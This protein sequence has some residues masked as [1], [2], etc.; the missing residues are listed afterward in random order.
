M[1]THT[2]QDVQLYVFEDTVV[3]SKNV[4]TIMLLVKPRMVKNII[5]YFTSCSE[6]NVC[7]VFVYAQ[8]S[9]TRNFDSFV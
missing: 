6:F 3:A 7:S 8:N 4:I 5:P 2:L 1:Y 9:E